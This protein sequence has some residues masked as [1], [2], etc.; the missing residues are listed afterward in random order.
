MVRNVK[1]FRGNHAVVLKVI[2]VKE[3]IFDCAGNNAQCK[4]TFDS[5]SKDDWGIAQTH[6]MLDLGLIGTL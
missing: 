3:T 4:S 5:K 1:L 2:G 6:L